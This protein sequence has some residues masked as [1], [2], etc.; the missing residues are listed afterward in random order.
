MIAVTE[1]HELDGARTGAFLANAMLIRARSMN[2]IDRADFIE[3]H[4]HGF[5]APWKLAASGWKPAVAALR[6]FRATGTPR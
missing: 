3:R 1:N 2:S 4:R 5:P 6:T